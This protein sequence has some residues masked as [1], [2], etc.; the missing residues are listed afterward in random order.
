MGRGYDR[1]LRER[2]V[3]ASDSGM[4]ARAAAARFEVGVA[5]AIRWVRRWRET[6]ELDD[7]PACARRSVL[8]EHG[9]WLGQ[10]RAA[11]PDLSCRAVSARLAQER[12]VR[13]HQSTLWYWLRRNG[14]TF[15]KK[16][17]IPDERGRGDVALARWLWRRGQHTIDPQ[18]LV[19]VDETGTATNMAPRYG[20]GRRGARVTGR[21]RVRDRTAAARH[22]RHGQSVRT[23]GT[24]GA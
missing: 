5:T 22:R 11:E 9:A 24:K 21:A 3:R 10:L 12:G 15:K 16:S 6:G 23:Q 17:L 2:V 14:V 4:S 7:A 19:F 1:A 18:R 13:V 8:D 20:W